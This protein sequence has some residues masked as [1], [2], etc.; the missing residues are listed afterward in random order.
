MNKAFEQAI[1]G[2]CQGLSE[3]DL[4]TCKKIASQM[5][6][7]VKHCMDSRQKLTS[8]IIDDEKG[9]VFPV[10]NTDNVETIV[11]RYLTLYP[12]EAKEFIRGFKVIMKGNE[13]GWSN[14]RLMKLDFK[15]PTKIYYAGMA[16]APDFWSSDNARNEKRFKELCPA[17]VSRSKNL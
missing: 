15:M 7:I 9:I 1:E 4:K 10:F 16:I 12:F 2:T 3:R 11:N 13:S 14:G 6:V 8:A 5:Q 17:L